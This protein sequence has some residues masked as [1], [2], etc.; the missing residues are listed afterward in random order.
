MVKRMLSN[1]DLDDVPVDEFD[2]RTAQIHRHPE[3]QRPS[4]PLPTCSGAFTFASMDR[5]VHRASGYA[6]AVSASSA[7]I[8]NFETANA[9]ENQRAWYTADGMTYL[10]P[11]EARRSTRATT[12]RL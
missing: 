1:A 11:N 2:L 7:R 10:Y 5:Y 8:S 12:G 3:R 4:P 6:F 9:G